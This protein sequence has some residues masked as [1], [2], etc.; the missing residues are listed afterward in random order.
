MDSKLDVLQYVERDIDRDA[1]EEFN[2]S[3]ARDI[4]RNERRYGAKY[5]ERP[6]DLLSQI[7]S[8]DRGLNEAYEDFET[9]ESLLNEHPT[10]VPLLTETYE[11]KSFAKVR[12]LAI[13]QPKPRDVEELW[14]SS[15]V[16][17]VPYEYGIITP[18]QHASLDEEVRAMNIASCPAG[19]LYNII[20]TARRRGLNLKP[21][22]WNQ[23]Q[24]YLLSHPELETIIMELR[25]APK[26]SQSFASL[27][28]IYD[29]WIPEKLNERNLCLWFMRKFANGAM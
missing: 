10:L 9:A 16:L 27:R 11:T 17:R 26:S 19:F 28:L 12:S 6:Y 15:N 4:I 29:F 1:D 8:R 23:A 24:A 18:E 7:V 25:K 13:L 5:L 21:T 3:M 20:L 14:R 22:D 2:K